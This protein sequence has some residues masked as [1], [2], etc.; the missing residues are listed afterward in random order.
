MLSSVGEL[1]HVTTAVE[2]IG[3]NF[4]D[5]K[6]KYEVNNYINGWLSSYT[7]HNIRSTP[8]ETDLHLSTTVTIMEQCI[9]SHETSI[10]INIR[11]DKF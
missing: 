9:K 2:Q 8:I 10:K 1:S 7:C 11:A 5:F 3:E 4:H 6:R